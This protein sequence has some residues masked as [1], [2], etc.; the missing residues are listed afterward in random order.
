[1][2]AQETF[3]TTTIK[4]AKTELHHHQRNQIVNALQAKNNSFK[5]ALTIHGDKKIG[6]ITKIHGEVKSCTLNFRME[7]KCIIATCQP[8]LDQITNLTSYNDKQLNNL[9]TTINNL[10]DR[11]TQLETFLDTKQEIPGNVHHVQHDRNLEDMKKCIDLLENR[12]GRSVDME[13]RIA[14]LEENDKRSENLIME[15]QQRIEHLETAIQQASDGSGFVPTCLQLQGDAFKEWFFEF[16]TKEEKEL[17]TQPCR[18]EC[19]GIQINAAREY[20]DRNY[21]S[22][23]FQRQDKSKYGPRTKTTKVEDVTDEPARDIPTQNRRQCSA[24]KKFHSTDQCPL[25]G[26]IIRLLD[27]IERLK[28]STKEKIKEDYIQDRKTVH[29]R[30]MNGMKSRRRVRAV[31]CDLR[32]QYDNQITGTNPNELDRR[33]EIERD[34][35]IKIARIDHPDL[36]YGSLDDELEDFLEPILEMDPDKDELQ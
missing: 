7:A 29:E 19:T 20:V 10:E 23:T 13:Q 33:F 8:L 1:M 9:H 17:A 22:S 11:A 35:I 5:D 14:I 12:N 28:P 2:D 16:F 26:P 32:Q 6:Y 27:W 24:C 4:T 34:A 21:K 25:K 15:L 3:D 30:Y 18:K 36:F 31:I